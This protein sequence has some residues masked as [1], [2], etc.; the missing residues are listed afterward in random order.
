[1]EREPKVARDFFGLNPVVKDE[2]KEREDFYKGF[3]VN[4]F[5]QFNTSVKD[6]ASMANGMQWPF[7][8]NASALQQFMSFKGA[9]E[10][11]H[12]KVVFDQLASSGFQPISTAGAYE[13]NHRAPTATQGFTLETNGA[14]I[15][16]SHSQYGMSCM[17]YPSQAAIEQGSISHHSQGIGTLPL[18]S[19]SIPIS[20]SSPFFKMHGGAGN[21]SS[22]KSF[23]G[24]PVTSQHPVTSSVGTLAGSFLPRSVPCTLAKPASSAAQLTI[25]YAGSVNV[26]DDIPLEKAQAIM[27]LAANGANQSVKT[28]NSRTQV[29]SLPIATVEGI[30][31]NSAMPTCSGLSSPMSA[32][33]QLQAAAHSSS[34]LVA[35]KTISSLAPSNHQEPPKQT[36]AALNAR[37]AVPQARKASLA[38]FL[39]KRKERVS[40]MGPYTTKKS[41]EHSSTVESGASDSPDCVGICS[42]VDHKWSLGPPLNSEVGNARS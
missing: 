31:S 23:G 41:P 18:S 36:P 16:K 24:I 9:Q 30:P 19:H 34:D 15:T 6:S 20:M 14:P 37:A 26:Y 21:P 25:F 40:N 3:T 10:D 29:P 4:D 12:K 2:A 1:M 28:P 32:T 42:K 22:V 11:R 39:E 38:R 7:S 8:I 5:G 27:F 35:V 33:S 17:P 13:T